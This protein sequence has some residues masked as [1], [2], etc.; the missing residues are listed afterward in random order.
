MVQIMVNSETRTL[1]LDSGGSG[2]NSS[3]AALVCEFTGIFT[4]A[5]IVTRYLNTIT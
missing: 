5:N 3:S 1:A 2:G 4:C